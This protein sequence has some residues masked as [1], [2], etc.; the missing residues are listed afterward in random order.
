VLKIRFAGPDDADTLH[1]FIVALATYEKEPDA[2]EVTP[3]VLAA[4]MQSPRPPFE[5]LLA[6]RD[7]RPLGFA[8][9]FQSY[10]TWRGRPGMYLEDLFVDQAERRAGV[11]R[12]LLVRLAQLAVERGHGRLEWAVLDWNAPAIGFY[13]SLGAVAQDEWTVHRLADEALRALARE[14]DAR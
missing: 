12:A 4:Q 5:C 8:L 14:P 9:F 13:R 7:G 11:G 6:E 3:A 2:V 1:R 10:S